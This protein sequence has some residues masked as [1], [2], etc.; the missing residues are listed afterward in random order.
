LYRR[1]RALHVAYIVVL[2]ANV[3]KEHCTAE[4]RIVLRQRQHERARGRVFWIGERVFL[5]VAN[6]QAARRSFVSR[7]S[8]ACCGYGQTSHGRQGKFGQGR[9]HRLVS[10]IQVE[11][12]LTST[13]SAVAFILSIRVVKQ[14]PNPWQKIHALT[15]VF[16]S[17]IGY[18]FSKLPIGN[19]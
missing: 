16:I 19:S 10:S 8:T 9:S 18:S 13:R 2:A 15:D 12:T 4:R 5:I 3:R 6:V 7:D 11:F 1:L 17:N 14:H